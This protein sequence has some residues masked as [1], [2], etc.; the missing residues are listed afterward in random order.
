MIS[1]E[2][3]LLL[4]KKINVVYGD[5]YHI[6][7]KLG[8]NEKSFS[9]CNSFKMYIYDQDGNEVESIINTYIDRVTSTVGF[10]FDST[11]YQQG[12]NGT[13]KV[14]GYGNIAAKNIIISF[15]NDGE[16]NVT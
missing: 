9:D 8:D 2:E 10:Y 5:Q 12:F 1:L 16:I 11:Q 4:S 6:Y 15:I 3:L 7:F 14:Q 13:Y